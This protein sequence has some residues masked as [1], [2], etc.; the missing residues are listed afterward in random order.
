LIDPTDLPEIA[1]LDPIWR[2]KTEN[3]PTAAAR[4]ILANF[5]TD[6]EIF[7]CCKI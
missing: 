6:M 1:A 7:L 4:Q 3:E 5:G 2:E